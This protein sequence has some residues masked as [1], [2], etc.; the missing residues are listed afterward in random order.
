MNRRILVELKIKERV[1]QEIAEANR[2]LAEKNGID[3]DNPVY[4]KRKAVIAYAFDHGITVEE[5]R[6]AMAREQRTGLAYPFN[7][8]K[9]QKA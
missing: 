8:G 7:G 3:P 2:V 5:A 9:K 1:E 4:K 6:V